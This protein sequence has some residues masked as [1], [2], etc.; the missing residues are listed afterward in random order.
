MV[1]YILKLVILEIVFIPTPE[2]YIP[3]C[4]ET[5]IANVYFPLQFNNNNKTILKKNQQQH[6]PL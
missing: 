5:Q 1:L 6:V 2:S 3:L 4:G